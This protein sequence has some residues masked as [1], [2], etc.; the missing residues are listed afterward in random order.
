MPPPLRVTAYQRRTTGDPPTVSAVVDGMPVSFRGAALADA[1]ERGDPFLA[2]GLIPAMVSGRA[3]DLRELP[4]VAAPLLTAV[5]SIQEIW[6]TWNRALHRVEVWADAA[7]TQSPRPTHHATFFSGG[8][9]AVHAALTGAG[10]ER[11]ERCSL[12]YINGFDFDA[13]VE[14]QRA[15]RHRLEPLAERLGGDLQFIDTDWIQLTRH[16]DIARSISHGGCLAAVAHLLAPSRMTIGAS[17]SWDHLTPWGSHPLLDPLWSTDLTQI[18]HWGVDALRT[19]KVALLA[20]H[21]DLLAAV[22]VCHNDPVTNCG[23]C[24][25]C[26][27]TLAVL[28]LLGATTAGFARPMAD[29]LAHYLRAARHGDEAAFLP[30]LESLAR[31]RGAAAPVRRAIAATRRALVRR[32]ALRNLAAAVAPNRYRRRLA[33][34]DLRPWGRGPAPEWG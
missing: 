5:D 26:A 33:A 4:P 31:D 14:Q 30:Q 16:Q 10:P 7:P 21:D 28:H 11:P 24:A 3:L 23:Q 17:Y 29:P 20:E 25:K 2:I 27:R 9:D 19:E 1:P 34:D 32:A 8:I 18:R 15:I 12:V 22:T 13:T 6:S